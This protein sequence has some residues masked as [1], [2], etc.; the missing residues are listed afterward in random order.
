[1]PWKPPFTEIVEVDQRLD[2]YRNRAGCASHDDRRIMRLY[3]QTD[4]L[5]TQRSGCLWRRVWSTPREFI[6]LRMLMEDGTYDDAWLCGTELDEEL[7][8]WSRGIFRYRD[9]QL[10][11]RWLNDEQ[12]AALRREIGLEEQ[13][14]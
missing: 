11:L 5:S 8:E 2:P 3:V 4:S 6:V 12:S 14:R 1:V 13:P 7:A 10:S 9:Q